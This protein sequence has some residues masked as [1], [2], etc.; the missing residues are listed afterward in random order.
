MPILAKTI[1]TER[2]RGERRPFRRVAEGDYDLTLSNDLGLTDT[3]CSVA[4]QFALASA[5]RG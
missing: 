3:A 5:C 4:R 1:G 2:S